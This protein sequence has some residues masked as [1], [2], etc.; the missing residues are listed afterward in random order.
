MTSRPPAAVGAS[1]FAI[2]LRAVCKSFAS[3]QANQD[4]N[5]GI[6]PGEV[7]GIVGENGAGK[8]T[9]MAIASG[10]YRPDA[11][12][13]LV[14]GVERH[15]KSPHDAIAVG[16]NMV[17]QHPMLVPS[18][19]VAQN[20]ALGESG[21]AVLDLDAIAEEVRTLAERYGLKVDPSARV[22]T[23]SPT[24]RQRVEILTALRRGQ[25]LLILDEPTSVLGEADIGGLFATIRRVAAEGCAVIF[26]S[27]KL[28]EVTEI[29]S[30]V[31]VMRHGRLLTTVTRE[32]AD[33]DELARLMVGDAL[34]DA[35]AGSPRGRARDGGAP[36]GER[37]AVLRVVQRQ[38]TGGDGAVHELQVGA[39]EV[40]GIAGVEGSG[41]RELVEAI[42]GVGPSGTYAV[43]FD[44]SDITALGVTERARLGI[45]Y[46]PEDPNVEALVPDFPVSW[47]LALR[48]YRDPAM[49]RR[50]WFLDEEALRA[51][52]AASI[53][54]FDVRGA[55]GTTRTAVLSGGNRQKVVLARELARDPRLLVIVNPSAGLDVGATQ[56]VYEV[57]CRHRDRG[58]AIV[59]V[60]TELDEIET[61]SDRIAVLYRGAVVAD[62]S[63]AAADRRKLGLLMAGLGTA[64]TEPPAWSAT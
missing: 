24:E 58:A 29:C 4:I 31:S 28:R 37:G 34:V 54:A 27:H 60:S 43:E 48:E 59:L 3:V 5:L 18:C 46:V 21:P 6:K 39:G 32:E 49:R 47:N 44:G 64:S 41:Q 10:L 26:T 33:A 38:R 20:V 61:L 15:F 53:E 12:Q 63:R 45:A 36:A 2:E 11:G 7:R 42:T 55:A 57:L 30:A 14:Q 13:V 1:P 23:L 56:Y 35:A 19:T 51:R 16:I 8:S 25:T 50:R 62:L 40:L 22:E 9:L 17:H 52:A